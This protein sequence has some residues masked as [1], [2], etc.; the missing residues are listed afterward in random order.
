MQRGGRG[1]GISVDPARVRQA[2]LAAGLSLAQLAGDDV[3]RTFIYLVEQ[4]RSRPSQPVLELIA[5]RT[6]KP[7][8]YFLSPAAQEPLSNRDLAAEL[9]SSAS[10]VRR[11]VAI[12]RLTK[13]EREAMK[14]IEVSLR[15]GAALVRAVQ[16]QSPQ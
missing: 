2:R 9:S 14:L 11:F 12:K 8:R 16:P 3:S 13:L 5:R 4:G 15:Q 1:S 7:V 6:G 10:R